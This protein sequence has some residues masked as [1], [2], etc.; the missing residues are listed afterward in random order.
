MSGTD[1]FS[2]LYG[3]GPE[4]QY[5]LDLLT[6]WSIPAARD[7]ANFVWDT[8]EPEPWPK[9]DFLDI[10]DAISSLSGRADV[11]NFLYEVKDL[12]E[13]EMTVAHGGIMLFPADPCKNCG[14][15]CDDKWCGLRGDED[16]G[17]LD[18]EPAE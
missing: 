4:P 14:L 11:T 5:D 15:R 13:Y 8:R 7:I 2:E 10:R 18:R 16:D 1:V 6:Y 9:M 12:E 3:D 17:V